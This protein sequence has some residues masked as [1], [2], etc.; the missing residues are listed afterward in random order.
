MF[1]FVLYPILFLAI[2]YIA[3][4]IATEFVKTKREKLQIK[5]LDKQINE[6]KKRIKR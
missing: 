4:I 2:V 6:I 1:D 5:D 3:L